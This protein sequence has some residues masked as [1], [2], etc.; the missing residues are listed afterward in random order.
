MLKIAKNKIMS[1]LLLFVMILSLL[2]P[3]QVRAAVPSTDTVTVGKYKEQITTRITEVDSYFEDV[4]VGEYGLLY[5][6]RLITEYEM[7]VI[8]LSQYG[9]YYG[10]SQT[11]VDFYRKKVSD[12]LLDFNTRFGNQSDSYTAVQLSNEVD[13]VSSMKKNVNTEIPNYL[14]QMLAQ[15]DTEYNKKSDDSAKD[16]YLRENATLITNLYKCLAIYQDVPKTINNLSVTYGDNNEHTT[17][18]S[19]TLGA[20]NKTLNKTIS[21]IAEDYKDIL[22]YGKKLAE[23]SIDSDT[24]EIDTEKELMEIFTNGKMNSERTLD[25]EDQPKLSQAYLAILSCSSV[26]TPFNSYVGSPEFTQALKEI[27]IKED[28]T[29]VENLLATYNEAKDIQ[30]PLYVRDMDANGN[31]VGAAHLI[32]VEEFIEDIQAGNVGA[33]VVAKGDFHYNSDASSWIYSQ[34]SYYADEAK[35]VLDNA[36]TDEQDEETSDE[37]SESSSSGESSSEDETNTSLENEESDNDS[38]ESILDRAREVINDIFSYTIQPEKAYATQ[39]TESVSEGVDVSSPESIADT[40]KNTIIIGDENAIVLQKALTTDIGKTEEDLKANNVFFKTK[41]GMKYEDFKDKSDIY[42][43]VKKILEGNPDTEFQ[44]IF[45]LGHGDIA[46]EKT[47]K[48]IEKSAKKYAQRLNTLADNW[49]SA[50]N[51]KIAT[52]SALGIDE[53]D[54]KGKWYD[55]EGNLLWGNAQINKFNTSL[56]DNIDSSKVDYIDVTSNNLNADQDGLGNSLE[57][58]NGV[59]TSTS[60]IKI[61]ISALEGLNATIASEEFSDIN[62]VLDG[63]D[64]EDESPITEIIDD[65]SKAL[66]ANETIS[67]ES[68]LSNPVL[69]YGT[70]F[71]RQVDNMT[72]AIMKNIINECVSLESVKNKSTRYLYMNAFGDIVLDDGMVVM[73]GICNPL[74][75]DNDV[76]S[77]NP[78]TVAFMNSYPSVLSRSYYFQVTNNN[79]VGKYVFFADASNESAKGCSIRMYQINENNNVKQ[80]SYKPVLNIN[81]AFYTNDVDELEMLTPQRFVFGSVAKWA[82]S[83]DET[84]VDFYSQSPIV[85]STCATIDGKI[86]FPYV[87]ADDTNYK[88]ASVIALNAYR[89]ISLDE[90]TSKYTNINGLYD[91]YIIENFIL[92]N[93]LGTNNTTGYA[94]NNLTE[95]NT[96]VGNSDSRI[97]QQIVQYSQNFLEKTSDTSGVIGVKSSYEDT[98]LGTVT[99]LLQE[100]WWLF[101]T[102]I[103][104]ILLVSFMKMHRDLLE[105]VILLVASVGVTYA[106]VFIVPVYLSMI[107]NVA[108]NNMC[109]NLSYEIVGVKTENQDANIENALLV[110]EN[111][112]LALNTSSITLYRASSKDL[113]YFYNSVNVVAADVTAG[114][115]EVINQDAGIFIEGDSIKVNLD[116]LFDTLP[117]TGESINEEGTYVYQLR[118]DKVVSNNV[119]YY[120]PYYQIV[121]GFIGKLNTLAEVYKIPRS[122]TV[123]ADGKSKDNFLVYSYVHSAPFLSPGN[124]E[125][126]EQEEAASYVADYNAL[127]TANKQLAEEL[128]IAFGSNGDWLGCH[129]IFT[130]LTE[131]SKK[132]LWAQAMQK[133]GYYDSEWNPNE[134]KINDL[135]SYINR[136]TKDFVFDME[137]QI[138]TLSDSTMIKLISLRALVAFTQRVSEFGNFLYPFS[139]NYAEFTLED[140]IAA[141]F[142]SD[143]ETY[144]A[145]DMDIASYVA[146]NYGWVHLIVF[147]ILVLMMFLLINTIKVIIPVLYIL[148]CV[149]LIVKIMMQG[150]LKSTFRGYAKSSFM[151][152]ALF[153]VYDATLVCIKNIGHYTISIYL[154]LFITL[155]TLG[156]ILTVISAIGSSVLDLGDRAIG[157]H[158]MAFVDK[159]HL[160]N[161]VNN[162]SMQAHTMVP[163]YR[164]RRQPRAPINLN[165]DRLQA[166]SLDNDVEDIY[167]QHSSTRTAVA[168]ASDLSDYSAQDIEYVNDLTPFAF[169]SG[170]NNTIDDLSNY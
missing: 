106:L 118:S 169:E 37:S 128:T 143:Y 168:Y 32:T 9:E 42:K 129:T 20:D 72:T 10:F 45:M 55:S 138:G 164:N 85:Q 83:T 120:T 48:A 114:N 53:S 16:S 89:H 80:V 17:K 121:D 78:Y 59:Y 69:L 23:A 141:V 142:T 14:R 112:N 126:E 108:I 73:P 131:E 97:S 56:K 26:Y 156:L 123:Y 24:L 151:I 31:P 43:Q 104:I 44:I 160:S 96:F 4:G 7:Y 153:T 102:I 135:I 11:D 107:Y 111:G 147:D 167:T 6:M 40:L 165:R 100:N 115:T 119:D 22:A 170:S 113:G 46:A 137:G 99:R 88:L 109:E 47:D 125:I 1:V 2:S 87:V 60:I 57:L 122:T 117:I 70:K 90:E 82:N 145:C 74:L 21:A 67:D 132:T 36:V 92:T 33:L 28:E 27:A 84:S 81:P 155:I 163:A 162:I 71:S 64:G 139:I 38:D 15:L 148:L 149:L 76:L 159:L 146:T 105:T 25:F 66:Y 158:L 39:T 154:L 65:L 144:I 19:S 34:Y 134:E 5:N 110:D 52:L 54:T 152:F 50:K 133:N 127:V 166:Y 49:Y 41:K 94:K 51:Y 35:S 116:I 98:I 75:Y 86:V 58:E 95:Y 77:Y 124:Y 29:L 12:K 136:Q 103:I 68:K 93:C 30:K 140:V 161:T 91:A 79:D 157:E 150:D 63:L 8:F 101:I 61:I 130:E 3:M 18:F 62:T 13:V